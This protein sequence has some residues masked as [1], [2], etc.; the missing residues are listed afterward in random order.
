MFTLPPI[1]EASIDFSTICQLKC[2]ACST[3]NGITHKS[4]V[5]K[6]QLSF[7]NF[8]AFVQKNPEIKRIEMSN[9]G[10]IFLNKDLFSILQYAYEHNIQLYCGNGANFNVVDEDVLE[11]LVK[12]KV[13]Y[14][15]L[16]IDG[17]SQTTYAMYRK[18]GDLDHV[19]RNIARLNYYK[20]L[21]AS[22]T[23]KLS[24][25]FIIFGHNEHELPLVKQLCKD[26]NMTFNPKLNYSDY[27]PVKDR[28]FV[29]KESGLGVADRKE[30]KE[31]YHAEYKVPCYQCFF[32]P[33]INWNGEIL[34]CCVN[35][36]RTLGNSRKQSLRNW[37][38]STTYLSLAAL[39]FEG[40]MPE[41]DLPCVHCPNLAK[42]LQ[43][44]LT[45]EGLKEYKAYV[46]PALR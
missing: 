5:G 15:N 24:W 8:I 23:P 30:Y 42:V 20:Q 38:K 37:Q 36:W 14:L 29:R 2:V 34:G 35:K 7:E 39:L 40:V 17:A 32:S 16:S 44:P 46:A 27:S 25:Q 45:L 18:G 10:E 43:H 41:M 11:G 21:Y 13:E 19:L 9:W 33:Q 3:A 1:T 6:G 28:E 4:I 31:K 26:Y 12:Y 22:D